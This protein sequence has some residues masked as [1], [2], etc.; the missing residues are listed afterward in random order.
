VSSCAS[1]NRLCVKNYPVGNFKDPGCGEICGGGVRGGYKLH[2]IIFSHELSAISQIISVINNSAI[3]RHP[4]YC[5]D[6][7]TFPF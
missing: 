6:R 4:G 7:Q 1:E 3:A 5:T 2:I